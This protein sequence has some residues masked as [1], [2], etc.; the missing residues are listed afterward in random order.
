[1]RRNNVFGIFF[2]IFMICFIK[3][4]VSAEELPKTITRFE[5]FDINENSLHLIIEHKPT[6]KEIVELMPDTLGVYLDE[7][8][9]V[10]YIEV[11]WF[12]VAED[13]EECENFYFQFS[14]TWD[15]KQ[16]CLSDEI[17]LLT[18]APYIGVFFTTEEQAI[19][20]LAVTSN[21]NEEKIFEYLTEVAGYNP[22]AACGIMA[23]IYCES[24][25]IPTNLEN[26]YEKKLGYNDASYTYAVDSGQ[27]NNFVRDAAGYGL[28]QWTYWTRK[29]ELLNYAKSA[30]NSIGD[31]TM[32]LGFL[33]KEL[34]GTALEEYIE[35]IPSTDQGAYKVGYYFCE[36]YENPAQTADE[37]SV[38]RGN[39]AK[40]TYWPE[41]YDKLVDYTIRISGQRTPGTMRP[42]TSFQVVGT[43][44]CDAKL[45]NITIGIYDYCGTQISGNSFNPNAKSYDLSKQDSM[46]SFETLEPGVYAY[47]VSASNKRKTQTLIDKKFIVFSNSPTVSDGRYMIESKVMSTLVIDVK[48]H[49]NGSGANLQLEY[50]EN[51]MYQYFEI[52]HI[53]DGYYTIKNYGSGKYMDVAG[54][55]AANQTNVQQKAYDGSSAQK[56]Q[57]VPV[58]DSYCLIPQ[59]ATSYCLN[60][61]NGEAAEGANLQIYTPNLRVDQKFKLIK[62]EIHEIFKDIN[63]NDWFYD[64]VKY[65]FKNDLMTGYA[66][67]GLFKP[68]EPVTR[69]QLITTLYRL[70]GE[71]SVTN[72]KACAVFSDI[73][74]EAYYTDAVNW[75]YNEKIATGNPTT[76]LFNPD[77]FVSRQQ[78]AT[79]FFRYAEYKGYNVSVKGDISSM[80][81]SQQVQKYALDALK[82]AVGTGLI[83]GSEIRTSGGSILYDLNPDG[84]ATR[85]QLAAILQRFCEANNI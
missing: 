62:G 47:K 60:V 3:V 80:L 32:Q 55:T 59:C 48:N 66:V 8:D 42:G 44:D 68:N 74:E 17:E 1:M 70:A 33:E 7:N 67:E 15:E 71:P 4:N 45:N 13:Y 51:T 54:G 57:I 77:N 2:I 35:A 16:Y 9:A 26:A 28:C 38:Y 76:G 43:I 50:K 25:F 23:N 24:A 82:W 30:G 18:E 20:T 29:Q 56:W 6:L 21:S 14:P 49:Y 63:K 27:Y 61:Q 37:K 81:N 11:D 41:Y 83:T 39:L 12:C 40:N 34:S 5:E 31:L 75:A 72:Y 84:T 52:K 73:S 19:S 22:A 79:F 65:V 53:G 36:K 58:G 10:V 69:A 46:L 64:S 85:A 78:L